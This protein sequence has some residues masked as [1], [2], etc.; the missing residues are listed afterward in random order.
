[1][2]LLA[3]TDTTSLELLAF[4]LKLGPVDLDEVLREAAIYH[5]LDMVQYLL[6][7]GA[8]DVNGALE[9]LCQADSFGRPG[10]ELARFL[11]EEAAA[12]NLNPALV[13]A[14]GQGR[15]KAVQYLVGQGATAVNQ[16]LVAAVSSSKG[17]PVIEYLLDQGANDINSAL[18]ASLEFNGVESELLELFTRRGL[19]SPD[20]RELDEQML[21]AF[22]DG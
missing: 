8:A 9:A 5:R 20:Y 14:A 13:A 17:M 15:L 11:V 2:A 16:A 3:A 12:T 19:L 21:I 7:Q 18:W 6:Q 4:L 1:M 22:R 10:L